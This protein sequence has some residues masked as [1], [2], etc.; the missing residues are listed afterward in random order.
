MK[1]MLFMTNYKQQD[2][3][4]VNFGF[5][6]ETGTKKRP[7]LIISSDNYHQSRQEIIIMAITSNIKRVLFGDTKIEQWEEA[8][9]L[10]PSLV[11]G[12]IRTIKDNMIVR[13]LGTLLP[14]DFQK[15]Q[16]NIRKLMG[17]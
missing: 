14:Q 8:G 1:R 10:Y 17:L 15:V 7:A 5:S 9:L 12:I 11:T 16:K 2:I 3:V 13:K 4:L 6:E